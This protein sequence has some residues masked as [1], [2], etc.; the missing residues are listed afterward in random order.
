MTGLWLKIQKSWKDGNQCVL[1]PPYKS[2]RAANAARQIKTPGN[3]LNS[4][5]IRFVY[6]TGMS[7]VAL[8]LKKQNLSKTS[9]MCIN[10]NGSK[11]KNRP[12]FVRSE[13]SCPTVNSEVG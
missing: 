13:E 3:R 9:Y 4:Y 2:S 5:S 6:Q 11:L 1:L 10:V 7:V 8:N 12:T